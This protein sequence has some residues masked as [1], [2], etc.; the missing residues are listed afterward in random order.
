[1]R[2]TDLIC[3]VDDEQT[4]QLMRLFNEE[5]GREYLVEHGVPEELVSQ[6]DLLGISSICNLVA[7]IKTA[8]WYGLDSRHVLFTPL[9]DSMELYSSRIREL[10]AERGPYT[11]DHAVAHYARYL[12]GIVTDHVRELT[13]FDRRAL[14]NLKYFTWVEQQGKTV[15]ELEELWDE[16]FWEDVFSDEQV[17]EWDAL[18]TRFNERTGLLKEIGAA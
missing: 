5:A 18:I 2:N 13:H 6:L 15:E 11:R 16:D 10:R 12:E 8:R 7:A 17:R 4:V 1:M 3:A 14:H 9:T